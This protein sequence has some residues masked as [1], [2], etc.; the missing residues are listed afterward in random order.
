MDILFVASELAPMIKASPSADVVASLS[1]ALRLLGHKVT[2]ALPRHPAIEAAG[3]MV[4]RRLTPLVVNAGSERVEITVFDGRLSSGVDL[5]LFDAEGIAS[6]PWNA[7]GVVE[8]D[9]ASARG[10][11]LFVMAVAELVRQRALAAAPFDVVHVHDWPAAMV[12][13]VLRER[14]GAGRPPC[15]LTI[16]DVSRQGIFPREALRTLGLGDQHFQPELLE[17]YGKVNFLKGGILAADALTTGSSTYAQEILLPANGHRLEGLLAARSKQREIVGIVSGVDYAVYNPMTDPALP[18]RYDAE[19]ASN[20][21]ICK[22]ALLS[23]VGLSLNP[24]RP[25]IVSIGPFTHERGGD[26][27]ASA[28]PKVLKG[29]VSVV[30][31]GLADETIASKFEVLVTKFP[32]ALQVIG[33]SS[34]QIVHRLL[35]AADIVVIPSRTEPGGLVQLYAQRYGALPVACRV[36]GFVDTIVDCDAA[37][38][39]GTGFLYDKPTA[40]QLLAGVQRAVA[41]TTSTRWSALRRRVMRQDLGWDRPARRYVHVYRSVMANVLP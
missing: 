29:D 19:D 39:T 13:Y 8:G 16:H 20:K 7:T 5:V 1:K 4:A 32:E 28:L 3:V 31:A 14:E 27:L 38:E 6:G 41:A 25:L 10:V 36:G 40:T 12:P 21:G 18:A 34:D 24:N 22:G 33:H 15:V 23:N 9:A 17:F 30:V 26:L 11:G 2:L 35:A 37:L